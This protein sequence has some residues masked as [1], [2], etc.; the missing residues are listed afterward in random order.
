MVTNLQNNLI[1]KEALYGA[2]NY[3]PLPIVLN[4]GEGV[5]LWDVN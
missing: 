4:K 5:Y 3:S 1:S 2:T